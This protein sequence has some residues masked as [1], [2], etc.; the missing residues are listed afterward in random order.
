M[1]KNVAGQRWIVYAYED[2][3][4]TNPG[5][6]VTGDAVNIT[7]NLRIDGG[8]AN[9]VDDTNPTELEDGFYYFDITQAESN[10]ELIVICPA[11]STANV[12][13]VGAPATIYTT[14]AN[15]PD[16]SIT[17]TNGRVDVAA[18]AGTAQTANDNGND[19]NTLINR[20]VGTIAAGTHE[21]QS[22]DAY[23]QTNSG[24]FGLAVI[25]GLV[26]DLETRL[27]ATRA[28]YLDE[29]GPTNI[30][31]DLTNI[32]SQ[33]TTVDTVVDGIQS[34]L[35]NGTDGLGAIKAVVDAIVLDTG[36]DGVVISTATAQAIA[37]EILKR[38]WNSVSGEAAR[39]MLN[40]LRFLRNKWSITGT[41]L[42]VT[43]EDDSTA[44]WTATVTTDAAADPVT[45][46][47]PA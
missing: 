19:I 44:A 34:D 43:Q 32:A 36:T 7:A 45:G 14:P 1:Q 38:D 11:S 33:I 20:I 10:G 18:V 21:P 4:G 30:P 22:G 24:T 47:D 6:P 25:E 3:G 41:T 46:N 12:N 28:G 16:L 39:S 42:T 17:A 40:A 15:Y 29:L 5:E 9:A 26:D 37:D 23:A 13:V 8:A 2:E 31:T 35:D 27:S